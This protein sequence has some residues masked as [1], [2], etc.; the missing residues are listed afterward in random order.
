[1]SN[2]KPLVSVL[3]PVYNAAGFVKESVQSIINQTYEN[4]EIIIINDGSTDNSLEIVNDFNDSRII[5]INNKV[6]MRLIKTLNL[7]LDICKGKY[8]ARMDSDDI[9]ELQ[10]IEKQVNYLETHESCV[11]CGSL[12]KYFSHDGKTKRFNFIAPENDEKIRS[13]MYIS[14]PIC[15]PA[16]MIRRCTIADNNLRFDENYPDAE[17]YHFWYVLSKFGKLHN[18]QEILLNYRLSKS[19][20]TQLHN[21]TQQ[22]SSEKIRALIFKED[23]GYSA[24]LVNLS[25]NQVDELLT[26]ATIKPEILIYFLKKQTKVSFLYLKLCYMSMKHINFLNFAVVLKHTMRII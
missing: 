19:Q 10:R 3:I 15:H 6:N 13:K 8:I 20:I 24:E 21:K 26:V 11:A 2:V 16:A 22:E 1:M 14:S 4:L 18:I 12:V 9:S 7:G 25:K 5:V 17:D 23:C